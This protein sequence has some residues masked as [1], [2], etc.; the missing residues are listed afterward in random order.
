MKKELSILLL[1]AIFSSCDQD[2]TQS[3]LVCQS[4]ATDANID[5][6]CGC[7]IV[8]PSP[9]WTPHA[10]PECY[11]KAN[12]T[13]TCDEGYTLIGGACVEG[14][15]PEVDATY[16]V[17]TNSER[18]SFDGATNI[19]SA[20]Y[21]RNGLEGYIS[22]ALNISFW[23]YINPNCTT[24]S[25]GPAVGLFGA[26]A[27]SFPW[28]DFSAV[29]TPY[30]TAIYSPFCPNTQE[31]GSNYIT[32]QPGLGI[33]MYGHAGAD[34]RTPYES[35]LQAYPLDQPGGSGLTA[36]YLSFN[37]DWILKPWNN[38]NETVA[39]VTEQYIP[40]ALSNDSTTQVQE[41][42]RLVAINLYCYQNMQPGQ[43]CQFEWNTQL[44]IAGLHSESNSDHVLFDPAQMGMPVI[45]G[46]TQSSRFWTNKG[47]LT[48]REPYYGSK[49]F[50]Y[51]MS[52][53]QAQSLLIE[54]TK[55]AFEARGIIRESVTYTEVATHFGAAWQNKD[56]WVIYSVG[57]GQE[58]YNPNKSETAYITG[59]MKSLDII[60]R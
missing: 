43:A 9:E 26:T 40:E 10:T 49:T 42:V 5:M 1:L 50:H 45:L 31:S 7:N 3:P 34:S 17:E 57:V 23:G 14:Y 18:F 6:I 39:V 36:T 25:N 59:L 52:W 46:S 21:M 56:Q 13:K 15:I 47:A 37:P 41:G 60:A 19:G 4:W 12:N 20:A 58:I 16:D 29:Q 2:S 33:G 53:T 22:N 54:F 38:P 8:P 35:V 44:F 32:I 28:A 27:A 51:E 11:Y 48:Q 24:R 55:K 30:A